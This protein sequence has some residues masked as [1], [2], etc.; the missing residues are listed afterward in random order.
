MKIYTKTGDKG[1][2]SLIYGTR[3]PKNH[4]RVEAYGTLDEANAAIGMA[5]SLLAAENDPFRQSLQRVQTL[6]FH[7]GAEL[8]TPPDKEVQWKLESKHISILESDIDCWSEELPSLQQFILP[9]GCP[10]SAALHQARTIVRRAE[11]LIV[12]LA[13]GDRSGKT[14]SFIN[15]LSDYLFVAAR[16]ANHLQGTEENPLVPDI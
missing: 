13:E 14:L 15:R 1:E 12:A 11:R 9:G 4:P 10:S 16:Y 5:L 8:A 3:V 6:L 2:T 7:A